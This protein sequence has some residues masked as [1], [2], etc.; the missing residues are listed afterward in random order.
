MGEK[1][2]PKWIK[3]KGETKDESESNSQ[4]MK[5]RKGVKKKK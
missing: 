5:F 1:M 2:R 4:P 3:G